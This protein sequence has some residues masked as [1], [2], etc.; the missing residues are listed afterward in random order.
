MGKGRRMKGKKKV[1]NGS[2]SLEACTVQYVCRFLYDV[3]SDA[4]RLL[5]KSMYLLFFAS[6]LLQK[7]SIILCAKISILALFCDVFVMMIYSALRIRKHEISTDF[8]QKVGFE[9]TRFISRKR[10]LLRGTIYAYGRV[11]LV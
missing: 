6:S 3:T 8:K 4:Y 5:S 10:I 7:I 11:S 9:T 2:S 1:E